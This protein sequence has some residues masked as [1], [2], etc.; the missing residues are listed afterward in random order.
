M[1]IITGTVMI[2]ISI[3]LIQRRVKPNYWYGYRTRRTLNNPKIWYEGNAYAGKRLLICG[4]MMVA[5]AFVLCLIPGM[6]IEGYTLGMMICSLVPLIIAL[7]Q[8][9]HYINQLEE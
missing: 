5:G 9:S 1:F 3:P 7:S 8:S 2:G 4:V 6:T